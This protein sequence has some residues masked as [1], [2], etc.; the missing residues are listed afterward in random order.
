M[1]E[2]LQSADGL[3]AEPWDG[4][5]RVTAL[6]MGLDLRDWEESG[7]ASRSDTMILL[8]LDPVIYGSRHDEYSPR[9][10]GEYPGLWPRKN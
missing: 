6:V 2:P 5:S 9:S 1:T 8:T 7:A 3:A 10:M 4:K